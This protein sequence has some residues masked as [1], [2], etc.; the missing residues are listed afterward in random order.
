[1][2]ATSHAKQIDRPRLSSRSVSLKP[3]RSRGGGRLLL[4]LTGGLD[5]RSILA[6]Y[7]SNHRRDTVTCCTVGGSNDRDVEV[8]RR[9]CRSLGI[10]WV[11]LQPV[12]FDL[13]DFSSSAASIHAATGSY[14]GIRSWSMRVP[15]VALA[16]ELDAIVMTGWG[17]RTIKEWPDPEAS[18][19][20]YFSA[21]ARLFRKD[22]LGPLDAADGVQEALRETASS[23]RNR[24][25][26]DCQISLFE[27]LGLAFPLNLRVQA[28][29][30][31][32]FGRSAPVFARPLWM[33][34]WFGRQFDER[35]FKKQWGEE[36]RRHYPDVFPHETMVTRGPTA[37]RME[38]TQG[39]LQRLWLARK[40]NS[41]P[42]G[43]V[44]DESV[45]L[46]QETVSALGIPLDLRSATKTTKGLGK[47]L[48]LAGH[49]RAGTLTPRDRGTEWVREQ[50]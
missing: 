27:L 5:S 46:A 35:I 23:A 19:A 39:R 44:V 10:D 4:P 22:A 48:S 47:I 17:Q 8:A 30:Q 12:D 9:V 38:K 25:P 42:Q 40:Q 43:S 29:V 16:S 20:K 13:G 11:Q 24:L 41:T 1:M 37:T 50:P 36:L 3:S 49:L 14:I 26:S 34:H 45:E 28:N 6:A 2:R 15:I 21:A 33:A 7:L 18:E 32:M 31:A